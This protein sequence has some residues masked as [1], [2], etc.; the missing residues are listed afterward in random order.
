MKMMNT[1]G[2][3]LITVTLPLVATAKPVAIDTGASKLDWVGKKVTGQHNGTV[4]LKSGEVELEGNSI[5]G[6]QFDIDMSSIKVLDLTDE[7]NNAKLTGH[8]KSDDFFGVEKHPTAKF[9]IT[10][11]KPVKG[12]KDANVEVTGDLTVKGQTNQITFPALV[13]VKDGKASAKGN[14][15]IDRT[16]YN[17]RYGS[18]KFFDNLGDKMINDNFDIALD[19]KTK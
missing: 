18:G 9:K 19:L 13:D 11:V 4:A 7:K 12:K 1:L 14:I 8:L 3:A 16:K 10:S 17:V 15:S 2:A 6:G 5:K